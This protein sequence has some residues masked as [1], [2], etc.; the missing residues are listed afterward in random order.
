M[1]KTLLLLLLDLATKKRGKRNIVNGNET[2]QREREGRNETW[3]IVHI[4]VKCSVPMQ[5]KET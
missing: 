2:E 3:E 1:I 5:M 4:L